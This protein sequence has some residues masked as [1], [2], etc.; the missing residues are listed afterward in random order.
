VPRAH[1]HRAVAELAEHDL[2]LALTYQRKRKAD[3]DGELAGDDAPSTEETARDVEQVHRAAPAVGAPVPPTEQLGHD[4]LG[5]DATHQREPVAAIAGNEQVV[6]LERT[7]RADDRGLLTGRQM[8]VAADESG[9]VL[10][11][12]LGLERANEHHLLIRTAK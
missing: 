4:R 8:A 9:L 11:L 10:A 2:W 6:G 5:A 3:G 1:V 7:H 12:G